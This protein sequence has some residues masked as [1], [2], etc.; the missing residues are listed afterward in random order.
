MEFEFDGE[1]TYWRGPAPFHFIELPVAAAR[2]VREVSSELTYGWGVIPVRARIGMSEW[3]TSLFPKDGGYVVP[4][5][6]A[7]RRAERLSLGDMTSVRLVF[8][9]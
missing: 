5:K 4:I 7:V 8:G 9:D 3:R 6:A 2:A 1:I